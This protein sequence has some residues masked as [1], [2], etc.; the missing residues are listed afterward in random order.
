MPLDGGILTAEHLAEGFR[1]WEDEDFVYLTRRG[2]LIA[3]FSAI[4]VTKEALQDKLAG[5][6]PADTKPAVI[7]NALGSDLLH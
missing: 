1:L 2:K 6:A 4:G 7:S 3:V 5:V